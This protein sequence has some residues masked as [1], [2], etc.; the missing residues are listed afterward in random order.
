MDLLPH[1]DL[2]IRGGRYIS[3]KCMQQD[4]HQIRFSEFLHHS[5]NILKPYPPMHWH[6]LLVSQPVDSTQQPASCSSDTILCKVSC[7][8]A[9]EHTRSDME[10]ERC[11]TWFLSLGQFLTWTSL[12]SLCQCHGPDNIE[13]TLMAGLQLYLGHVN[14]H[15]CNYSESND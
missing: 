12:L 8:R 5:D 3:G 2:G 10:D 1:K 13:E 14:R 9:Q 7:L 15:N 4:D 11:K 6:F